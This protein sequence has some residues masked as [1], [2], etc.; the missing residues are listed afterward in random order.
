M[1]EMRKAMLFLRSIVHSPGQ[2]PGIFTFSRRKGF[3]ARRFVMLHM[4][5]AL[6]KGGELFVHSVS[7]AALV[8]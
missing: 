8:A 3:I 2:K 5:H 7:G 6:A 4:V 1:S